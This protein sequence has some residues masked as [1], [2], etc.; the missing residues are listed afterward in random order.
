MTERQHRLLA[1][2]LGTLLLLVI[3]QLG[4]GAMGSSFILPGPIEVLQSLG[5]I[6]ASPQFMA[7]LG[8]T[9]ARVLAGFLLSLAI[10]VV[11]GTAAGLSRTFHAMLSPA[12]SVISAVPVLSIVLILMLLTGAN[13]LPAT[14]A[15]LM[16]LPVMTEAVIGGIRGIEPRLLEMAR[17]YG[18][19]R[20]RRFFGIMLPSFLSP[21][22]RGA[23]SSLGLSWKVVIAAEV[24]V[25]P[26]DGMGSLM[27]RAK[28]MLETGEVFAWTLA[29]VILSAASRLLLDLASASLRP[30]PARR[31]LEKVLGR[32]RRQA[33]DKSYVEP[34]LSSDALT[35]E[36]VSFR[37]PGS[38]KSVLHDFNFRVSGGITVLMG[39]S[40]CGKTTLLLRLAEKGGC[41]V[42]F[43]EPRL[44]PWK[45]IVQNV[46]FVLES[47]PPGIA[48]SRAEDAL[49]QLGLGDKMD[50][51]PDELSGGQRQRVAIAR[52]LAYP[53]RALLM[54]EAFQSLDSRLKYQVLD[55]IIAFQAARAIPLLA[56]IH[57][58][59]EAAVLAQEIRVFSGPPLNL[60]NIIPG[61]PEGPGKR[62]ARTLK[63]EEEILESM[64]ALPDFASLG[65]FPDT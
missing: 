52:A 50:A 21:L 42:V 14:A 45:T 19:G 25:Q 49:R 18:V 58:P 9:I 55:Q 36:G 6:V 15:L 23:A 32:R 1:S 4:A 24:L 35:L 63:I 16:T 31:K 3:W 44:L 2:T 40:G 61:H 33:A 59:R 37:Y 39:P 53:S 64:A 47:L 20:K 65:I 28:T 46:E 10:S 8:G 48:A 29:A 34:E 62:D 26:R 60:V 38:D 17:V 30:G 22:L 56:V 41:A 7:S 57:D 27:Y 51:F 5:K 43:Q 54:D 11:L 12:L 13:A